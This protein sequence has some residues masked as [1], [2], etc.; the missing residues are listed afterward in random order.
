MFVG[1]DIIGDSQSLSS[2]TD[3]SFGGEEGVEDFRPG[4]IWDTAACIGDMDHDKRVVNLCCDG[5]K[6]LATVWGSPQFL[7][8]S[9]STGHK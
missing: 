1:D 8:S 7:D 3:H 6:P 5:Y 9:K 4:K 2:N